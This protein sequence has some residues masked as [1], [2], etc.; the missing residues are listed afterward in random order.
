MKLKKERLLVYS[1][2]DLEKQ[3][4]NYTTKLNILSLDEKQNYSKQNI[5]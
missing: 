3:L 5:D 1:K 2:S 4:E